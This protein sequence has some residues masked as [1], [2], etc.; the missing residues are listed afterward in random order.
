MTIEQTILEHAKNINTITRNQLTISKS[1]A[2]FAEGYKSLSDLHKA[3][4]MFAKQ[5]SEK[6]TMLDAAFGSDHKTI[7][8]LRDKI[9]SLQTQNAGLNDRVTKLEQAI[10]K[11]TL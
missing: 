4:A 5:V 11:L 3:N 7:F 1:L 9:L 10:L 2:E 8:D 6:L